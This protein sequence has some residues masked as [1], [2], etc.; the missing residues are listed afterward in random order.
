MKLLA[1]AAVFGLVVLGG[2]A[3]PPTVKSPCVGAPGSPCSRNPLPN[4]PI[5]V[6]A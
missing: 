4:E 3:S 2:C 5:E 6:V 1:I